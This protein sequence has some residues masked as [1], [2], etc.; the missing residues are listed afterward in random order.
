[1]RA[2]G[3]DRRSNRL[4]DQPSGGR[5]DANVAAKPASRLGIRDQIDLHRG[6]IDE[7]SRC[8]SEAD[9]ALNP[10]ARCPG[11]PQKL[12]NYM[13]ARKAVVAF[14]GSAKVLKHCESGLVV[15]DNDIEAFAAA[16][17]RLLDD[18]HLAEA[19][20][21]NARQHVEHQCT[22]ERAGEATE[23]VYRR[24]LRA[25]RKRAHA[26]GRSHHSSVHG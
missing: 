2:Q 5:A 10:R 4:A 14:A 15:P 1:V 6:D 17:V 18:E 25:Y 19:L 13:A 23:A 20:G 3:R 26:T 21:D 12:L 8:L 22:W 9:V 11:I 7:A 24:L 16:C